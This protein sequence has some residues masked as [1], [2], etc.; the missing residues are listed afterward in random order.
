MV[1]T[2]LVLDVDEL[3]G[4]GDGLDVGVG[5]GVLGRVSRR[6]GAAASAQLDVQTVVLLAL[7]CGLLAPHAR[8]V[9]AEVALDP[10]EHLTSSVLS[11]LEESTGGRLVGHSDLELLVLGVLLAV[12]LLAEDVVPP[13]REVDRQAVHDGAG[14]GDADVGPA[15]PG[16]LCAV[17][18]VLLPLVD[19]LEVVDT[20]VVVVLAG[21]DDAVYVAGVGIRDGVG[22]GVPTAIAGVKT[23]HERDLVVDQAQLLVVSPEEHN[24]V[25]GTVEGLKG[26]SGHLGQAE[27]AERQVLEA[28]LDLGGDV[29]A[30][31]GVVRVSE[32]LD[33]L[34]KGL[35]GMLGVLRVA[36]QRLSDLLVHDD[37]NLDTTLGGSL[38]H[39]VQAVLVVLCWRA[40]QEQL[41]GQPPIQDEDALL[42]L[43]ETVV[44]SIQP[45]S[46]NSATGVECFSPSR[47]SERAQK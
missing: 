41:W 7:R 2:Y 26:V 33:V 32:H 38:Q 11:L 13:I 17:E 14:Q 25:V 18:L 43:C 30:G 3:L 22:V 24:V 23:A 40:A 12:V 8:E 34:V 15:H 5:N 39:V 9:L 36:G 46:S 29:L 42:G 27:G 10:A 31:R 4:I 44:V 21:V 1:K 45:R 20:C 37:V 35:E 6:P 47:A 16:V 19:A 28:S